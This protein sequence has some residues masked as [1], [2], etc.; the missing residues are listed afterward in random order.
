MENKYT[1]KDFEE[2]GWGVI[3]RDDTVIVGGQNELELAYEYETGVFALLT[4]DHFPGEGGGEFPADAFSS[5]P[6]AHDALVA[7][8]SYEYQSLG[9]Y[10]L[11]GGE[12]LAMLA[13]FNIEDV[14]D[15]VVVGFP[16]VAVKGFKMLDVES[17]MVGIGEHQGDCVVALLNSN[18]RLITW[19]V[20]NDLWNDS[21]EKAIKFLWKH[22]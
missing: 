22:N 12:R 8:V 21:L 1:E 14:Q 15:L 16:E 3:S 17:V 5:V 9:T 20:E 4:D 11:P 13:H 2:K 6:D 18:Q 10:S 19:N 7:H